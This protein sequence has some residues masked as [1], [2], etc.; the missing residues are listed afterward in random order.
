MK[1]EQLQQ[2]SLDINQMLSLPKNTADIIAD[3]AGDLATAKSL[4]E[5]AEK[6]Q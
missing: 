5:D 6:K 2:L 3:T 4:N 1:P